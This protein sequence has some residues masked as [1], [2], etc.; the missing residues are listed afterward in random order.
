[1]L[2]VTNN[3]IMLGIVMPIVKIKH[4]MLGVVMLIV[5]IKH[6]ML[7]VVMMSVPVKHIM[8]GVVMLDVARRYVSMPDQLAKV[9][10][11]QIKILFLKKLPQKHFQTH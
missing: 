5:T 4:I 10:V 1:M 11:I 8:L 7:G 6:I 2:N 3:H 9:I